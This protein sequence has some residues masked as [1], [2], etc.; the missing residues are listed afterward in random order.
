MIDL[1]SDTQTRPTQAMR[2]AIAAAEVG[3]EQKNEDPTV[4]R[5]LEMTSYLLGKEAAL[6][7]PSGTMCNQIAVK[8][9]TRPG[10]VIIAHQLAHVVRSEGGGPAFHSSVMVEL[11]D[12]ARG[13]F[14]PQQVRTAATSGTLY[15]P[16]TRLL[17]VEQTHNLAGGTVWPVEQLR[18]V[19]DEAH[20][21]G[22]ATHMDG[23]RLMNAVVASTIA[24]RTHAA[25]C[26]SVWLDFTKGL[27]APLGAVLAGSRDFIAQ[28]RHYKHVMGG[29]MRQAGMM[30]AGCVYAL[31][32]HVE[33]LAEDHHNARR[34]AEGLADMPG[35]ELELDVPDTNIVFFRVSEAGMTA[36]EFAAR[37]QAAGVRV[38]V[39]RGER[40]RAVTHLDVTR[41]D[42]ERALG[43][44]GRVL[45]EH[46]ASLPA[47]R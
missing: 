17:C 36:N 40:I 41:A 47:Q 8:T 13:Q 37:A 46:G 44:I 30:A 12:G 45:S 32:H 7:L 18:A 35:V 26:D 2:Q 42:I 31:E 10:D 22:M 23:A 9:H 15:E 39:M 38:G 34:L 24:A 33:R 43:V 16:P 5:L 28:A 3:D 20:N 11:L 19:C 21:L 25:S 14:T 27:G 29:A 1:Y 4:N 6:F